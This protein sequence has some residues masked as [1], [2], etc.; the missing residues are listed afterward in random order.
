MIIKFSRF[1]PQY[2]KGILEKAFLNIHHDIFN[3]IQPYLRKDSLILDFGCG[4]G[5]FSQRLKDNGYLVHSSDI[6][7]NQ[8]K[9]QVD[10][11]IHL[12]LNKEKII[13][14][15]DIKYDVIIAMEIIEHIENPWKFIRDIKSLLNPNG[16][17]VLSTP[18][19]SNFSSRIRFLQKGTFQGFEENDLS[20]GHITTITPFHLENIFKTE[21]FKIEKKMNL[22]D[23][24]L[25]HFDN[26]S[27]FVIL[28]TFLLPLLYPFMK[29]DKKSWCIGYILRNNN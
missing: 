1:K 10:K 20:Y 12:D 11:Y 13:D 9:A 3:N 21:C 27:L 4:E 14:N 22:G 8:F 15:F 23:I 7:K 26:L 29:G 28:K 16:I 18:N 19:I 5:A 24:P 6:D 2:Y 25:F 17:L